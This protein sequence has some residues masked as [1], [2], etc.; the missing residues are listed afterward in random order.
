MKPYATI[1]TDTL[2]YHKKIKIISL[3]KNELTIE[4]I[5]GNRD[6]VKL[7]DVEK[8]QA[9]RCNEC[10]RK[11]DDIELEDRQKKARV[12]GELISSVL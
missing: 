10:Y 4:C 7:K 3:Y 5:C 9:V 1:L 12:I 11:V 8:Y 6:T 2:K